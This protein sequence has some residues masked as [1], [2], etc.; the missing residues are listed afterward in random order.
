MFGFP[1]DERAH[2]QYIAKLLDNLD[3]PVDGRG[4]GRLKR[5]RSLEVPPGCSSGSSRTPSR[6]SRFAKAV[7]SFV[8][9]VHVEPPKPWDDAASLDAKADSVLN[10]LVAQGQVTPK[11]K[12]YLEGMLSPEEAAA[13]KF[14]RRLDERALEIVASVSSERG[15]VNKAVREGV[16][17]ISHRGGTVRK[18]PKAQIA[19]ELALRG[20]RSNLT[21]AEAKGA[22]ETLKEV[23]LHAD[24]WGKDLKPTGQTPEELRDAALA[25]L[26]AGEPGKGLLDDRGA[27]RVLAR[28][29]ARPARGAL[30][31]HR[32][33]PPRRARRQRGSSPTS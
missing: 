15:P 6:R 28:R 26:E 31:R 12:A 30:L 29:A 18:E 13:A 21:V 23:Y 24:I 5:L 1:R 20:V 25:E 3:R 16:L 9:L 14:P 2:R 10:E 17:L 8:H 27:G 32:Q 7:E 33:E 4:R 22:R 11:R 19:V